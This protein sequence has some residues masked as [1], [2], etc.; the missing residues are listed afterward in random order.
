VDRRWPII[1]GWLCREFNL[2]LH[3]VFWSS[4]ITRLVLRIVPIGVFRRTPSFTNLSSV[5]APDPLTGHCY[6]LHTPHD[7]EGTRGLTCLQNVPL[8]STVCLPASVTLCAVLRFTCFHLHKV[9]EGLPSHIPRTGSGRTDGRDVYGVIR[10]VP[11]I[12]VLGVGTQLPRRPVMT[13]RPN[14]G[15]G[16]GC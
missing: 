11:S 6:L 15:A 8:H 7:F 2:Q 1:F 14:A 4:G 3:V 10:W 16:A 12:V 13:R 5:D 9:P